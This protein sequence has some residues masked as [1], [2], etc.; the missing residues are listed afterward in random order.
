MSES[1]HKPRAGNKH[2][3]I[4]FP[5]SRIQPKTSKPESRDLGVSKLAQQ[6]GCVQANL[7]GHWCKRHLVR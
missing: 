2:S 1:D 6:L 3:V 4:K 7:K 5:Q